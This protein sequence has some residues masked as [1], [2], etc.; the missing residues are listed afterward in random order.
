VLFGWWAQTFRMNILLPY[1]DEAEGNSTGVLISP[2]PD[3]EGNKLQRQKI[4]SFV[5]PIYNHNWRNIS[6]IYVY[7]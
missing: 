6:T 7:I 5:Y 4:L 2:Q 1:S 3:K